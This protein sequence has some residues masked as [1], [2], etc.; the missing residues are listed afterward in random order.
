MGE[1]A[2]RQ[3]CIVTRYPLVWNAALRGSS[4]W[5]RCIQLHLWCKNHRQ[6]PKAITLDIDDTADTEHGHQKLSQFNA[7]HDERCFYA[8]PR[9]RRRQRPLRADHLAPGKNP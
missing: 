8:G 3:P 1:E 2:R 6:P 7:Y 5:Q 4:R 9:L